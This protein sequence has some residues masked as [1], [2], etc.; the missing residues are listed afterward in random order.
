VPRLVAERAD[1]FPGLA[2]TFRT[3]GF[4][5]ASLARIAA[6]TGL[7]KGSLYHFFPGGKEEMAAA[8]LG[9]IERWFET[10]VFAPL[11]EAADPASGIAAMLA[12]V[13]SYFQSGRRTCLLGAFALGDTRDRFARAIADYFIAWRGALAA[14]LQRAGHS[15][16]AADELAEDVIAAIQGALVL[17]RALDDPALFT[18]AVARVR[19]RLGATG[20]AET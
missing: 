12:T 18:R 8:I 20:G 15:A 13:A 19:V 6:A 2:E 11:R 10:E 9:E 5:G 1:T 3:Y 7:G 4:E 17:A 14:A 16:A